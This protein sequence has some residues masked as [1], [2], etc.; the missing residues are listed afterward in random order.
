MKH[1]VK[2][3]GI[4]SAGKVIGLLYA[5]F[6]V[7]FLPFSLLFLAIGTVMAIKGN[8]EGYNLVGMG[9]FFLFSPVVYGVL[10]FIAG[11][12]GALLYNL[13]SKKVGG[14]VFETAPKE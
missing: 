5:V 11:A 13:I 14:I 3:V 2:S 8:V 9:I 6:M 1:E 7:I 4:L 12:L 10:G